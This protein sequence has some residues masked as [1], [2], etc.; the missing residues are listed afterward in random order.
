MSA[1]VEYCFL[2]FSNAA[3][4]PIIN[5]ICETNIEINQIK[6]GTDDTTVEGARADGTALQKECTVAGDLEYV[7][8]VAMYNTD[9]GI[10]NHALGLKL[11]FADG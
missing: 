8:A 2:P 7:V 9:A 4:H 11:G 1:D 5:K 3:I 6:S 10:Y